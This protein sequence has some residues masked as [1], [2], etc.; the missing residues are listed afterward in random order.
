MSLRS[1]VLFHIVNRS[2]K[3]RSQI[4]YTHRPPYCNLRKTN[5]LLSPMSRTFPPQHTFSECSENAILQGDIK[6]NRCTRIQWDPLYATAEDDVGGRGGY[7]LDQIRFQLVNNLP[8][9]S[10]GQVHLHLQASLVSTHIV[11]RSDGSHGALH[12]HV[13]ALARLARQLRQAR[14]LQQRPLRIGV[15]LH[16]QPRGVVL[17]LVALRR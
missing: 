16:P 10:S 4:L 14:L 1:H 12:L 6:E 5:V 13:R 15:V 11:A 7:L 8:C 2:S 3:R 9:S 17:L